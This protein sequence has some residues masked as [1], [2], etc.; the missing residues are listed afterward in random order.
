MI[1]APANAENTV[2]NDLNRIPDINYNKNGFTGLRSVFVLE[3]LGKGG[4][5]HSPLNVY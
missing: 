4:K 5:I 2:I 1:I 3:S